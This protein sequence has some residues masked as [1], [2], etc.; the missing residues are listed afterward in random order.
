MSTAGNVTRNRNLAAQLNTW[1]QQIDQ[2]MSQPVGSRER[3]AAII[4]FCRTFVPSDVSEADMIHY[5]NT[6]AEDE[7]CLLEGLFL[8]R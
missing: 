2:A 4:N 7:V 5:A 3:L 6:L 1:V 8:Y